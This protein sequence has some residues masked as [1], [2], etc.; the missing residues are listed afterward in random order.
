MWGRLMRLQTRLDCSWQNLNAS[1]LAASLHCLVTIPPRL[2]FPPVEFHIVLKLLHAD[3]DTYKQYKWFTITERKHAQVASIQMNKTCNVYSL[4][5]ASNKQNRSPS[6]QVLLM[7][8]ISLYCLNL[9]HKIIRWSSADIRLLQ[10]Y[11]ISLY[12]SWEGSWN[13]CTEMPNQIWGNSESV[14][15]IRDAVITR[16]HY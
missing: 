1:W 6:S 9:T 11:G 16:F 4:F 12:V 5:S 8:E 15:M 13:C 2:Q 14:T 10:I 7:V 3:A